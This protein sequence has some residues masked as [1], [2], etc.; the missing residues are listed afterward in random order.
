MGVQDSRQGS[1]KI[2]AE[3]FTSGMALFLYDFE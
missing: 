3:Y 1:I 2:N